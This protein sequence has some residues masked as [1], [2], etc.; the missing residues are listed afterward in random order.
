MKRKANIEKAVREIKI[1]FNLDEEEIKNHI[2]RRQI[3]LKRTEK[4]SLADKY[5]TFFFIKNKDSKKLVREIKN[6]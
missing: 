6:T 4:N 2:P 1:Q 3:N 5:F